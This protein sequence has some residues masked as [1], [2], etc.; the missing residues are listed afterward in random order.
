MAARRSQ[1]SLWGKIIMASAL[2]ALLMVLAPVVFIFVSA[3]IMF[4]GNCGEDSR[5]VALMRSLSQDELADLNARIMA[6]SKEYP[7]TLLTNDREPLIP[8]DLKYLHARYIS[9]DWS[10]YIVMAKCN[11]SVG[12][13]VLFRP[14]KD[15]RDTIELS[16][17][18]PTD[19]NPYMTGS[20]ILW[21]D[22]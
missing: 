2:L 17:Y 15:G 19:E 6:L 3:A 14:S 4:D 1:K 16:W 10:P 7:D 12:V 13:L 8:E 11:V 21:T 5:P 9:F 22:D 20:E 18:A